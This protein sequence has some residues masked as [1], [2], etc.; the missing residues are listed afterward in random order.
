MRVN[1][2]NRESL[3]VLDTP[4]MSIFPFFRRGP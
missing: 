2:N 1:S 3:S 4:L